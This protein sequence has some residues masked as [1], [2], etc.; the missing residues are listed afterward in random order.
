MRLA[1]GLVQRGRNPA[2]ITHNSSFAECYAPAGLAAWYI[3]IEKALSGL[4]FEPQFQRDSAMHM[5]TMS[6]QCS[7]CTWGFKS[8]LLRDNF[9]DQCSRRSHGRFHFESNAF[10]VENIGLDTLFLLERPWILMSTEETP[11]RDGCK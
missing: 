1:R 9:P 8:V 5:I 4:K 3:V 2:C 10:L 7:W 11:A 6:L